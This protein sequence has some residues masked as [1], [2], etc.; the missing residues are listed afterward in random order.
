MMA[1]AANGLDRDSNEGQRLRR[2]YGDQRPEEAAKQDEQT[3]ALRQG[4]E[5]EK[6]QKTR[7]QA[8]EVA[9]TPAVSTPAKKVDFRFER[10]DEVKEDRLNKV[11]DHCPVK[12]W[13]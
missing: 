12:V 9:P 10:S 13:V 7:R 8:R 11:S 4:K 3:E 5:G 1:S 6:G 2:H